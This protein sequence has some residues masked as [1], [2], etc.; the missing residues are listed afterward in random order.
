MEVFWRRINQE[1]SGKRRNGAFIKITKNQPI[2]F[3]V[4]LPIPVAGEPEILRVDLPELDGIEYKLDTLRL[5][6]GTQTFEIDPNSVS[7]VGI[8]KKELRFPQSIM[9][10]NGCS[11]RKKDLER[12]IL[13]ISGVP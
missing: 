9:I 10:R 12:S 6:Y 5:L 3:E 13:Y 8:K 7:M 1:F 2:T 4:N 11:H